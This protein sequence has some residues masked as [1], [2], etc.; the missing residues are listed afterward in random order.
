MSYVYDDDP[1]VGSVEDDLIGISV[2]STRLATGIGHRKSRRIG[3]D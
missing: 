2:K 1:V 3:G